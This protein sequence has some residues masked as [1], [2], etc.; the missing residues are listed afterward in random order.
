MPA[1]P[2]YRILI[3]S[4]SEAVRRFE[5]SRGFFRLLLGVAVF[6]G[7]L[8]AG[9]VAATLF[10]L[11]AN[12]GL[13]GKNASLARR[14]QEA[15]QQATHLQNILTL[16]T[17]DAEEERVLLTR[18][19]TEKKAE[20]GMD[21]HELQGQVDQGVLAVE[22]FSAELIEDAVE[23]FFDAKALQGK[24]FEG[25]AVLRLVG[26]DG[27][28]LG[29]LGEDNVLSFAIKRMITLSGSIPLLEDMDR[30]ELF[31]VRLEIFDAQDQL[32]FQQVHMLERPTETP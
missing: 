32:V 3:M 22:G 10:F 21:L 19:A 14:L 17:L 12:A 16:Q 27:S 11:T 20:Q 26:R 25:K 7:L 23:F 29:A 8:L 28:L 1:K 15:Q 31:G 13:R 6:A 9:C 30:E 4:D 18:P 24:P 5:V 2:R